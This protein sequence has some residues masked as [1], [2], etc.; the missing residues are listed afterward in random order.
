M[1]EKDFWKFLTI[2]CAM[3]I[4]LSLFCSLCIYFYK[5]KKQT[6]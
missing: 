4:I 6:Q 3:I 1:Y 5:Q 2:I